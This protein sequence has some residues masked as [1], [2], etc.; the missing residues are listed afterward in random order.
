MNVNEQDRSGVVTLSEAKGLSR[1]A[2]RSFASLRMTGLDLAG[3]EE[4]S[5]AFESCLTNK[6]GLGSAS[7]GHW[8]IMLFN[9]QDRECFVTLRSAQGLSMGTEMLRCAQHDSTGFA[10]ESSSSTLYGKRYFLRENRAFCRSSSLQC[11]SN[12][13]TIYVVQFDGHKIS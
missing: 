1:S 8:P 12:Y 4:L 13:V 5:H 3:A 6:S 7:T 9:N 11:D 2:A 10:R